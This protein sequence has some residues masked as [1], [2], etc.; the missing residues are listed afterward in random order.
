MKTFLA[1]ALLLCSTTIFAYDHQNSCAVDLHGGVKISQQEIAFFKENVDSKVQVPLYKIVDDKNLILNGQRIHLNSE[2]Q[3]LVTNYAY[4]IRKMIPAVKQVANE[5]VDLA[6][7]GVSLA[8]NELLGDNNDVTND[9][10]TELTNVRTEINKRFEQDKT[11]Y[12]NESGVDGENFFDHE[13]E[14]HIESAVERA[15]KKSIG[16][17][18]VAVGQKMLFSG[19]DD[20]GFEQRMNKFSDNIAAKM[21]FKATKIEQRANALCVSMIRIDQLEEQ[22]KNNIKQLPK[23]NI[24]SVELTTKTEELAE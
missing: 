3:Q 7:E 19:E 12:I 1:S 16:N 8:F 15:I 20:D 11:I 24:L 17:L 5:G 9:F 22:L 2:Q 23:F 18:L 14:A 21:E 6:I 4:S 13:F 10:V